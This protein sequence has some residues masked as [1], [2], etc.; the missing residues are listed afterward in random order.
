MARSRRIKER[1][2]QKEVFGKRQKEPEMHAGCPEVGLWE[3]N[4]FK[5]LTPEQNI[6]YGQSQEH[7]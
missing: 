6:H 5:F 1:E 2:K 3:G 4:S 7:H